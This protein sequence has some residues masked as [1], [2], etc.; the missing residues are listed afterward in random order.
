MKI[1]LVI[2]VKNVAMEYANQKE[3]NANVTLIKNVQKEKYVV[4]IRVICVFLKM[5]V[6]VLII[7]IV[8]MMMEIK[9]IVVKGIARVIHV[10]VHGIRI[11]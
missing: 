9:G 1:S 3:E 4:K 2:K 7:L 5:N 10:L 11:A 6:L 8:L